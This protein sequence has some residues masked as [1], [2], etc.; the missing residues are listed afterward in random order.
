VRSDSP[1]QFDDLDIDEHQGVGGGPGGAEEDFGELNEFEEQL[2]EPEYH[3]L[4]NSMHPQAAVGNSDSY[5]TLQ[6]K[7]IK[8]QSFAQTQSF[9]QAASQQAHHSN[10]SSPQS[11]TAK[12]QNQSKG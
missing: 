8:K 4:T 7:Y 12:I 2:L 1:S 3:D 10:F 11:S 9:A 6:N 5:H